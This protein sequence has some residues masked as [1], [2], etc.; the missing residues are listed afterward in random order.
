MQDDYGNKAY[1]QFDV[2][3]DN[4]F[5][6]TVPGST[7]VSRRMNETATFE[8]S[9]TCAVGELSYQWEVERRLDD[10]SYVYDAIEGADEPSYTT[11]AITDNAE[12]RCNISDEYG[13]VENINFFDGLCF[14]SFNCS[15]KRAEKLFKTLVSS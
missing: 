13:N 10:G 3:L 2:L 12:Y 5:V 1:V 8:V 7:S 14:L 15:F 6:V 9:A 11:P 4:Q